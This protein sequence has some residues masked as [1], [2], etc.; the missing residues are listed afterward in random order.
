[1]DDKT[2]PAP[3]YLIDFDTLGV[4][5]TNESIVWGAEMSCSLYPFATEEQAIAATWRHR[6]SLREPTLREVADWLR[7]K[8]SLVSS[9]PLQQ[10]LLALS[11]EA[12]QAA[13]EER[14]LQ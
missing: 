7:G 5:E 1:M 6:A 4:G 8:A 13:N 12:D 3:G 10:K 11:V 2:K 9:R 14:K